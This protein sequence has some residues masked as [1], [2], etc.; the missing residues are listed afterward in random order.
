[1]HFD[2]MGHDILY[3]YQ[4]IPTYVVVED[5]FVCWSRDDLAEHFAA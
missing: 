3:V 4:G 1:M 5:G 2:F